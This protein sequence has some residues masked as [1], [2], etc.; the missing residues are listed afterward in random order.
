MPNKVRPKINRLNTQNPV[1]QFPLHKL[2]L[3]TPSQNQNP[4]A[5]YHHDHQRREKIRRAHVWAID[6]ALGACWNLLAL[7]GDCFTY[8]VVDDD[9]RSKRS[10]IF[11][12][13]VSYQTIYF[14]KQYTVSLPSRN[15]DVS[16]ENEPVES[17]LSR[18]YEVLIWYL[19]LDIETHH[20]EREAW[21]YY[22]SQ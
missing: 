15:L 11:S 7:G 22:R 12:G 14:A 3:S 2:N 16:R 18:R 21:G 1:H 6:M 17:T 10:C 20:H 19:P 5:I 8:S 13:W 9:A 4:T